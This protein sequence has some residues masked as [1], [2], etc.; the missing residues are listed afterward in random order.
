MA[1]VKPEEAKAEDKSETK[2][3]VRIQTKAPL[4]CCPSENETPIPKAVLAR[5]QKSIKGR[6]LEKKVS[7]TQNH[8]AVKTSVVRAKKKKKLP[9]NLVK[10]WL[11]K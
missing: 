11:A 9:E 10:R 3:E 2:A 1:E 5:G 8:K 4:G 6:T 7:L